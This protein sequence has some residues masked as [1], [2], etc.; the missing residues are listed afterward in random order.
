MRPGLKNSDWTDEK[1]RIIVLF[2]R[3]LPLI[4]ILMLGFFF[5]SCK[6]LF[7]RDTSQYLMPAWQTESSL[8]EVRLDYETK[9][10]WNPLNQQALSRDFEST[11][12]VHRVENGELR[13]SRELAG[14]EGWTLEG[15]LFPARD[16][17]ILIRGTSD[18][19]GD[20]DREVLGFPMAD[21][22]VSEP[23]ILLKPA[24]TILLA[25]PSPDGRRLVIL[26]T[27]ATMDSPTGTLDVFFY[28]LTPRAAEPD[29]QSRL[30]H[31]GV[32]GIPEI[33]WAPDSSG[34]FVR[35]P[36]DI[37]LAPAGG[38]E[39]RVATRFPR[40]F[41]PTTWGSSVSP[42]G[43]QALRSFV[44]ENPDENP[45]TQLVLERVSQSG[46]DS[47]MISDPGRIGYGC[48]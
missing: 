11:I 1:A 3:T 13:D 4:S 40:C 24:N 20:E 36:G 21:R 42:G 33:A 31:P 23:S 17:I 10:S 18:A 27:D 15:S 48:P 43:I 22:Q 19:L 26:T 12:I 25:V 9:L 46:Y 32:P 14:Y 35:R 29:G 34:L 16:V 39:V 30:Q 8:I 7:W 44:S 6:V 37:V 2:M 38:G 45:E 47:E 41:R 5:S 28:R